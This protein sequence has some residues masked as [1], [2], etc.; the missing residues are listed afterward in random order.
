MMFAT[1]AKKER[2]GGK[3]REVR[4]KGGK[5]KCRREGERKRGRERKRP[6]VVVYSCNP[7][8]QETRQVDLKVSLV[9]TGFRM[10]R[11]TITRIVF[12]K[13]K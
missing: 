12:K 1:K 5:G 10:S 6:G 2:G 3:G 9:Y 13:R 4:E 11:I 7:N 8:T